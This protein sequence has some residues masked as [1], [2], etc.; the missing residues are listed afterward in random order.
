MKKLLLFGFLIFSFFSYSQLNY[1]VDNVLYLEAPI[2]VITSYKEKLNKNGSRTVNPKNSKI[3]LDDGYRYKVISI[4]TTNKIT[5]LEA[6]NFKWKLSGSS[7]RKS[8]NSIIYEVNSDDLNK[9]AT[10]KIPKPSTKKEKEE[11]AY[12]IGL[13]TLPFKARP[14]R[15]EGGGTGNLEFDTEFNLSST[16]NIRLTEIQKASFNLQLGAGIGSVG[17]NK[18]NANSLPDEEPQDV[19]TLTGLTGIMLQYKKVQFGLYAG[20][21]Y[22]NNQKTFDWQSNGNIWFGVGIGY[23]IFNLQFSEQNGNSQVGGD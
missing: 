18:N 22:I 16:L 20:V 1:E 5:T 23:Q 7:L 9:Y 14:V 8:Y 21:D 12:S 19:T 17:L 15:S 3:F 11:G 4:D 10:T 6:I 13:L 2:K